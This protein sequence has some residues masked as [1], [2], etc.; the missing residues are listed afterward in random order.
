MRDKISNYKNEFLKLYKEGNQDFQIA[1][2]LNFTRTTVCYY[3]KHVLNL[4]KNRPY[5]NL[6]LSESD[7]EILAGLLLGDSGFAHCK[8]KKTVRIQTTYSEKNLIYM[9]W[10]KNS[11]NT[12]FIHPIYKSQNAGEF[13]L[14]GK[15]YKRSSQYTMYTCK[16][17]CLNSLYEIFN[18]NGENII[19][20]K[21]LEKY[22]TEKSLAILFM[23]DGNKN[24]ETINL[25]M[26]S[27]SMENL[28]EF[29]SFLKKKFNLEFIIKKDK[30]LYLK[31][32]SR[33][34]FYNLV[35]KYITSDMEYKLSGIVS[36]LN[37]V[38]QGNS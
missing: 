4:P 22:F 13:V 25:N 20:I 3:R 32:K 7:K 9:N 33:K 6:T 10:I 26:Q 18:Q 2:K 21:Y 14:R 23:D 19:P 1:E 27:Y 34:L 30:T 31:Y 12:L 17:P 29:V 5:Q 36:S 11:L 35:S 37:S 15:K 24:I 16:A 38:K 28:I 8:S